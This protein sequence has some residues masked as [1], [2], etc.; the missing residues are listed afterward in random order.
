MFIERLSEKQ[1]EGFL[2]TVKMP[3]KDVKYLDDGIYVRFGGEES[4]LEFFLYDFDCKGKVTDIMS[5]A[6]EGILKD[7]WIDY[8]DAQFGY[9]YRSAKIKYIREQ[10][11]L[12]K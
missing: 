9:E 10:N 11:Q 3:L 1:I 4:D 5:V 7:R 6:C 2:K 8:L 12:N